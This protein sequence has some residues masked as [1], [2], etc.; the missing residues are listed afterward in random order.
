MPSVQRPL[1]LGIDGGG[2]RV[3]VV[4]CGRRR[5]LSAVLYCALAP[6][7]CVVRR[8][9]LVD[10]CHGIVVVTA[11]VVI[12][13]AIAIAWRRRPGVFASASFLQRSNVRML[14]R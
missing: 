2:V 5:D 3:V 1:V 10:L 8:A 13:V 12:V 6:M 14:R 7:L 11:V 4:G 9:G